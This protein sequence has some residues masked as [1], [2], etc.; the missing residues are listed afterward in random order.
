MGFALIAIGLVPLANWGW[1]AIRRHFRGEGYIHF[2]FAFV[3]ILGAIFAVTTAVKQ[4]VSL[5]PAPTQKIP[6][7]SASRIAVKLIVK[8]INITDVVGHFNI[9]N[10][11]T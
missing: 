2:L 6:K 4:H 10:N 5:P 1:S 8:S 9:T 3:V 7:P 11:E